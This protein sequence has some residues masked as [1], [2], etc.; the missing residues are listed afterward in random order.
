M[1]LGEIMDRRTAMTGLAAAGTALLA[2]AQTS[3]C[4]VK[5]LF[6]PHW[7]VSKTFTINVL[8]VM[9]AADFDFKPNPAQM[10]FGQLFKHLGYFNSFL[11]AIAKGEKTPFTPVRAADKVEKDEARKYL[12]ETF[13]YSIKQLEQITAQ[14]V[15]QRRQVFPG[16]EHTG[17]ELILRA[18]MHTAHHRGQAEVY[19]RVKGLQPPRFEF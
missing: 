2:P 14:E 10:S 3:G 11:L 13:D 9:P 16:L 12:I 4:D 1:A 17:A 6:L 8:E 7:K 5:E 19:L 18:Y 15:N